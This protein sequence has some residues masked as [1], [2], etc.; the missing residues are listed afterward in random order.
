MSAS[1]RR[2]DLVLLLMGILVIVPSLVRL[3]SEPE[4]PRRTFPI[5]D[6]ADRLL[7]GQRMDLNAADEEALMLI[8][9]VGPATAKRIVEDRAKRGDY[10]RVEQIERVKGIGP[11]KRAV[12]QRFVE[13]AGGPREQR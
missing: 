9:G 8:P 13:V 7:A 12:I 2:V 11:K 10:E 4:L 5:R 6:E 1:R 3:A